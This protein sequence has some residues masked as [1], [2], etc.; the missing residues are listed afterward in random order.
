MENTKEHI[1]TL[2][3]ENGESVAEVTFKPEAGNIIGCVAITRG[4]EQDA[5]VDFINVSLQDSAGVF[6]S[7]AQAIQ[8]YRSRDAEYAKACKPLNVEGGNQMTLRVQSKQ[9]FKADFAFQFILIYKKEEDNCY[10]N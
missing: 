8:N 4:D 10:M 6:L 7:K 3:V 1:Q 5:N 9:P 2:T